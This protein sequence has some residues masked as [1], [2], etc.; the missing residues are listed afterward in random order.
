MKDRFLIAQSRPQAFGRNVPP[1]P[2]PLGEASLLRL[3][4]K[5]GNILLLRSLQGGKGQEGFFFK[6]CRK[7]TGRS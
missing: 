6:G 5:D 2:K 4:Y 7:K 3:V 1:P